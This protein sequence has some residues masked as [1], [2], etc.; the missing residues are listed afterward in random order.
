[1]ETSISAG[2]A[3]AGTDGSYSWEQISAAVER[4]EDGLFALEAADAA[5][6]EG[7]ESGLRSMLRRM[8]PFLELAGGV[9]LGIFVAVMTLIVN[10][11]V[12][13]WILHVNF[14]F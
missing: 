8:Q 2:Q 5:A 14:S 10:Y 7:G 6:K 4:F 1:M 9:A 12:F 3:R 11:L 13:V